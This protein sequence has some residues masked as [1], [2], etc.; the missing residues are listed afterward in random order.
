MWVSEEWH[1][2]GMQQASGS[3]REHTTAVRNRV[4]L[5]AKAPQVLVHAGSTVKEK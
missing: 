4:G 5:G 1:S 2:A 3:G